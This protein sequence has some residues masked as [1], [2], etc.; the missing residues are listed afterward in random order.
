[1]NREVRLSKPEFGHLNEANGSFFLPLQPYSSVLI[2][3][4]PR[5]VIG[6][7]RIKRALIGGFT[8]WYTTVSR[9]VFPANTY[10][11]E[12]ISM[13]NRDIARKRMSSYCPTGFQTI[14]RRPD[15]GSYKSWPNRTKSETLD[16]SKGS[17]EISMR[18]RKAAQTVKG[19][20]IVSSI[21]SKGTAFIHRGFTNC[22]FQK[23]LRH[24]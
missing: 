5:N 9:S 24:N 2:D 8:S 22:G 3:I 11:N 17:D 14:A 7:K 19:I 20:Y 16:P 21:I 10:N 18:R 15:E 13:T 23:L 6:R 4:L 1:M 12:M